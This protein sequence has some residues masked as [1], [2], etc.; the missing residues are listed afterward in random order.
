M[1][2]LIRSSKLAL[3]GGKPLAGGGAF[4]GDECLN[5]M[6]TRWILKFLQAQLLWATKDAAVT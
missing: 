3:V 6:N 4:G 1:R 5:A 2:I